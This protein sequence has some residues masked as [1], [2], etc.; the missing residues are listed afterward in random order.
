ML[1]S[2]IL[3]ITSPVTSNLV[4]VAPRQNIIDLMMKGGWIM[5]P[6]VILSIFAVYFIIDIYF[7]V[8]KSSKVDKNFIPG[9]VD[10]IKDG[11][12]DSV[13]MMC[14][15]SSSSLARI[16]GKGS[17]KIGQPIS[18]IESSM[19]LEARAEKARLENNLSFLGVISS[20]APM[21]GFL[22]TIFGV[23]KIFYNISLA[24]NISIG[25][26]SGGLYQ[27]MISSASGLL[28]GI[29]AY[30][31]FQYLRIRISRLMVQ[32]EKDS[33]TFIEVLKE[34]VN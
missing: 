31:G 3:Q 19:E 18:E 4:K 7:L 13:K 22:G 28:I 6:L 12:V 26:I 30:A 33:N 10:M 1:T 20:I 11:K 23:I 17:E 8:K 14:N 24:D 29:F 34:P 32:I 15:S 16:I 5:V 27:K 25:I 2:I 9:L 21:F